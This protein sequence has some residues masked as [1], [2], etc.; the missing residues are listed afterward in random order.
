MHAVQTLDDFRKFS[1]NR[2]FEGIPQDVLQEVLQE[3]QIVSL[4]AGEVLFREGDAGDFLYL[5]GSGSVEISQLRP[6]GRH[7]ALATMKQGTFFGEMAL[8][9]GEPRSATAVAAEPTLL[10]AVNH[11]TFHHILE[12]APSRLH[13]NFLHAVTQR[14][15]ALTAGRLPSA[16]SPRSTD[17]VRR[18]RPFR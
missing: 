5:V 10:A 8:L 6:D 9:D 15:R 1:A 13:M 12:L 7:E 11:A 4:E 2:L 17:V 14:L 3:M 18:P 16:C